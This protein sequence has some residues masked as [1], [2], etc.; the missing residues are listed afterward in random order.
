MNITK[1]IVFTP[2]KPTVVTVKKTDRL[3]VLAVGLQK[4]QVLAKHQ[5]NNPTLLIV[6]KGEILFT[7]N[8]ETLKFNETDTYEIPVGVMHEVTGKTDAIFTLTQEL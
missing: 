1:A 5:T 7:I 6:L 3:R 2:E 4:G 8:N